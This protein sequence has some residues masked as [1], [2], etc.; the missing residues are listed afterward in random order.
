MTAGET[1]CVICGLLI[2]GVN[3]VLLARGTKLLVRLHIRIM[4]LE[5]AFR[6]RGPR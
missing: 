2:G 5:A 3:S 6:E 4:A 1:F